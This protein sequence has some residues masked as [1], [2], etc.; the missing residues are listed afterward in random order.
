MA[1][2]EE[3]KASITDAV[4]DE[5]LQEIK[6]KK[7]FR[8]YLVLLDR[9]DQVDLRVQKGIKEFKEYLVLVDPKDQL[10]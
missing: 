6:V 8:E 4:L 2:A 5:D 9:K 3:V 7:E 1:W 10:D